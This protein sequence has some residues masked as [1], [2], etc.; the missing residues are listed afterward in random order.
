MRGE[1]VTSP[2]RAAAPGA[3]PVA[4]A[5][6]PRA[7][8]R[9]PLRGLTGWEEEYVE[10]HQAE[11]NTARLCN[12]ILARCLVAPGEDAAAARA[13]VRELL[14]AVRAVLD[15]A[16]LRLERPAPA[17]REVRDIPIE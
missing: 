13:A 15:F 9:L 11:P 3:E 14:V 12:E 4:E 1:R 2:L 6:A 16:I 8:P 17:E 7:Q 5:A 10:R